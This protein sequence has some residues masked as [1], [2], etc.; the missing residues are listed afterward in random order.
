MVEQNKANITDQ[1][2]KE[3][4][5]IFD[6]VWSDLVTEVG[7]VNVTFPKE[8][9]WLNGAPG[10]GKGTQTRFIMNHKGIKAAPIV[11]SDLLT[12]P[13]MQ[14]LKDQGLMVGDKEVA[15]LLFRKIIDPANFDGVIVDGFPRTGVQ[16][17]CLTIL[18]EK[19]KEL[20][21]KYAGTEHA[22][23]F[24]EPSFHIIILYVDEQ[25]SVDRQ[26][27]RGKQIIKANETASP[28]DKQELRATDKDPEA[29]RKRYLTYKDITFPALETLN[30]VFHYHFI[31][32]M[33][34]IDEVQ[35]NIVKEMPN[36]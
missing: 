14:A 2:L 26:L 35:A 11:V 25:V 28:E 18:N 27:Y 6:A 23:K 31:D 20:H 3:A 10:A 32:S 7:E 22:A 16:V 34:S 15:G 33:Q 13:E 30:G 21:T 24:P 12:T 1:E 5:G 29:A 19:L 9:Y 8:L 36:A 4:Q 17:A